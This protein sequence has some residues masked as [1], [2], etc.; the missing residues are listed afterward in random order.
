MVDRQTLSE[1]RARRDAVRERLARGEVPAPDELRQLVTDMDWLASELERVDRDAARLAALVAE[2][3]D[4]VHTAQ[5]RR[6]AV[7]DDIDDALSRDG[8]PN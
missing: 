2:I 5:D 8:D 3:T 4:I 7:A 1:V 6:T